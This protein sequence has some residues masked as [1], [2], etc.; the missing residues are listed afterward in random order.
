MSRFYGEGVQIEVETD[1]HGQPVCF[2]FNGRLY[3]V[4]HVAERWRIDEDWWAERVCREYF[5]VVISPT[6]FVIYKDCTQ[7][8]W[9]MQSV[10]D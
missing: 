3:P 6:C 9:F 1:A 5:K 10:L 4:A 2:T 8:A 7:N